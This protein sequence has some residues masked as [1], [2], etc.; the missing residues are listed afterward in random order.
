MDIG[1]I[2]IS[3]MGISFLALII[4][5]IFDKRTTS[6]RLKDNI[7]NINDK[8]FEKELDR[9]AKEHDR[10]VKKMKEIEK[11]SPYND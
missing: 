1:T 11:N 5:N 3:I 9:H 8:V 7:K 2:L 10:I 4:M 6:E